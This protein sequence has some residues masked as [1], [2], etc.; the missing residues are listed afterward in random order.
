MSL[1]MFADAQLN[2]AYFDLPSLHVAER[3]V[4]LAYKH[5]Q[6]DELQRFVASLRSDHPDQLFAGV[7]RSLWHALVLHSFDKG[8]LVKY[9]DVQHP[10]KAVPVLQAGESISEFDS[11]D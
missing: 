11:L 6:E 7:E 4:A 1:Q 5:Q 10:Q 8:H 2:L 9:L 3:V